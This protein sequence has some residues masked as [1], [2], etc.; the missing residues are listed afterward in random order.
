MSSFYIATVK[1][2]ELIDTKNGTKEKKFKHNYLV[3]AMSVT[4]AEAVVNATLSD[5]V[6]EF[7][8]INVKKS[9]IVEVLSNATS[10]A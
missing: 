3:D 4:E 8:V 7:E 5:S 10:E 2:T 1:F 9:T 6:I